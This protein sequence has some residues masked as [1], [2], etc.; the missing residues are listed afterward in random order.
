MRSRHTSCHRTLI[1]AA[2]AG[3]ACV[4]GSA[5]AQTVFYSENFDSATLNNLSGD[6]R[7]INA[8]TAQTPV[9][10]LVPPSGWSWNACGVPTYACRVGNCPPA[11]DRT[12]STCSNTAGFREY[13]GWSY[14]L[15]S[16]WINQQGDQ[17]RSEFTLGTGVVAVAD[18]DGWDDKGS[19]ALNCGFFNAFMG[20][21][22]INIANVDAGGL[23]VQFD[24]S[25]RPEGF[26]DG[27]NFDNNQT[28]VIRAIYTVNG[29]EQAPVE[30]LRWDSD[31]GSASGGAP[32]PFFK[33]DS[34]NE[35]VVLTDAVLQ[36][37]AGATGVRFEFGL[38]NAGND[39][40]WAI[41]NVNVSGLVA[42]TA[43]GL[44]FEDFEGVALQPPVDARPSGC[45]V[46]Y[47]G[48]PTYTHDGPNGVTVAVD[49][50]ASGGVPDWFGWSFVDRSFWLCA[51]GGPNGRAFTNSSGLVAVADGDEYD[52]L[53]HEPGALDTT[54]RTPQIDISARTSGV[55][56]VTF[57]SSWR[58]ESGQTAELV[59]TYDDPAGTTQ[60]VLRWESETSSPNFKPDAVNE[61][62]AL[63][64]NVPSEA[65]NVRLAFRYV[66][67][68]NW[69][70][71]I[72]NL[73]VFQGLA[74]VTVAS[75]TPST[76]PMSVAGTVDYAPC[77]TPWSPSMPEG[78]T[79]FFNPIGACPLECGRPEWRGWS[80]AFRDWWS[81][82]VDAQLREDFTR[83]RGYVAVADPDEWD[84]FQNNR[85]NF[86]AFMT[87][88]SITLPGSISSGSLN[89][90]SSWRPEG[91]DDA[92]SCDEP[93]AL[94]S[95]NQTAKIRAIY[96]VGGVEQAPVDVL[97]WDSD[98]GVNSG[99]GTPSPFYKPD[100]TNEGV[101]IPLQ[102]LAIP[103]GATAVRFEF[104]LTNAR[105]DWWW[106]VDNI[107]FSVNGQSLFVEDF[108]NASALQ[109]PPSEN[110]PVEQCAYFSTVA[111]QNGNFTVDNS[112]LQNCNQGDDFYGFNA[113]IADAW[114][115]EFGAERLQFRGDTAYVSDF[116]AREC[117]GSARL[118]SPSY[119]VAGINPGSLTLTFRSSWGN[120]PAH[121]STVDVSY[122]NGTTWTNVLAWTE[123]NKPTTGDEVVTL[124]LNNPEGAS[125]VAFRFTDANSGWWAVGD[126]VLVGTVGEECRADFDGDT[127]VDFFDFLAFV[128]CFEDSNDC[129]AGK[130]ADFDGDGF[131]DFFD[132]TAFVDAFEL[133]C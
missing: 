107:D 90:D 43:T 95:N 125:A 30:V 85:S 13:E 79:Q 20:T 59:A 46:N 76:F 110:P 124:N 1:L 84:D 133:G 132:F 104:S 54:L 98:D 48:I 70:W 108:E 62:V 109:A 114:A 92:C 61:R 45:G 121:A 9:F 102:A 32:S 64:L 40:W 51:S 99:T 106:A 73:S 5:G 37:P 34:T 22:L 58:F 38:L 42:G 35:T 36:R 112:G 67:G 8:C 17:R 6:P 105:N 87:T 56:V 96:T 119:S 24:S 19:P 52:D 71:A 29:V 77:F 83:A 66:G 74:E 129:P 23:T 18:P 131:V 27:R 47:C 10:T 39:W 113:W 103:Q 25:W 130:T 116:S 88:P 69:W 122:D 117:S 21:P 2:V 123:A 91:F 28:G 55:L 12:C 93:G 115:R 50:P 4:T 120:A 126:I 111:A 94:P 86:N 16:F 15:K 53:A 127:F 72:D 7:V 118:I 101:S 57:D 68:N 44:F 3:A 41:D 63:P 65:L 60:T 31:D 82:Q 80:V 89:F 49:A 75:H 128:S 14:M 100:S 26:D 78:W 33:T 11:Q 81:T 97:H